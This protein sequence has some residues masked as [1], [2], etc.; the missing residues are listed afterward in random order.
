MSTHKPP[1]DIPTPPFHPTFEGNLTVDVAI[2]G[3]GLTGILSAYLL[4]NKGMRVAVLEKGTIGYGATGL[5]TACITQIID[6]NLAD[7]AG[8][9]GKAHASLILRSHKEAKDLLETVARVEN[10]ECEFKNVAN[11]IYAATEAEVDSL[12]AELSAG[13]QLGLDI[14]RGADVLGF[15]HFGYIELEGQ[16]TFHPL[17]FLCG[18]AQKASDAGAHIFEHTEATTVEGSTVKRVHTKKGVLTADWVLSAAYVPFSEPMGLFFKK[19]LYLTYLMELETEAPIPEGMYEDLNNPYQYF[20]ADRIEGKTRIILGGEDHRQ[21]VPVDASKNLQALKKYAERIFPVPHK[22]LRHWEGPI[23]EPID[24]IAFIG[25]YKD[26]HMLYAFGFSGNGM[27]YAGI[28]AQLFA[29]LI[30]GVGNPYER[31]YAA[32]R[33]PGAKALLVKGR[34]YMEELAGGAIHN[35][36]AY[37]KKDE[38]EVL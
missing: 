13:K 12:Q 4:A 6:T 30:E 11:R 17:R 35:S 37:R 34:D 3:G 1:W 2:I 16:A 29:D 14:R 5:T 36:L 27:T 32:S 26:Q 18:I 23:L 22:I 21:D 20:R 31:I 38:N 33:V 7:L 8:T 28:A 19:A 15:N 25:P 9:Y 24:G 10:I